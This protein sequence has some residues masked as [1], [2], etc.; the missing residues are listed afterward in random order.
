[1]A[2]MDLIKLL[3]REENKRRRNKEKSKFYFRD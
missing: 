2:L 3:D 1:M